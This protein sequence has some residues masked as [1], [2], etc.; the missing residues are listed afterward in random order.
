MAESPDTVNFFVC[1][2]NLESKRKHY[3][4]IWIHHL[5]FGFRQDFAHLAE[6]CFRAFGDRVKLWI[7][8]NEPN[9]MLKLGYIS[10]QFPPSHCSE[11]FG[12]CTC[13]DSSSEPYIAA[14]NIIL[15]HAAAVDIYRKT[16]QVCNFD[17]S[18][19]I[20]FRSMCWLANSIL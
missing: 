8:F 3:L 17:I 9:V 19:F 1:L 13:G 2:G 6:V 18:T 15:S 7:T 14:H 5:N 4:D 12:N 10:G 16:Y 11:P 20:L